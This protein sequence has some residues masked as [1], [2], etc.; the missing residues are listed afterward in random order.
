M[1]HPAGIESQVLE[2]ILH[3]TANLTANAREV[4]SFFKVGDEG[5]MACLERV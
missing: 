5:K 4:A 2:V 3:L 1:W